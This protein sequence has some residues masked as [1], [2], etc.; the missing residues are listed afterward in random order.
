VLAVAGLLHAD[1]IWRDHLEPQLRANLSSALFH[2]VRD[3]VDNVFAGGRVLLWATLGGALA[4]WQISG[5][6][7]AVMGALERIYDSPRE[8]PRLKRYTI[9]FVLSIELGVCFIAVA[10]CLLFAPF[11][12]STHSGV[13]LT[14]LGV[15]IR[16]TLATMLLLLIVGLLVRHAPACPQPLPWVSLGAGI[17]IGTWLVVS[18]AFYF[19][20]ADIASYASVFGSLAAVI[21]AFAYLYVSTTVFLFGAQLDA[22][23]RVRTTGSSAGLAPDAESCS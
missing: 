20:L 10:F 2:V 7:R 21:V 22:I 13:V 11:F 16:W 5:A 14:V 8:R 6:V 9:S 1:G 23:I 12:W 18:G 19:Y 4:L 3:S 15:L 17:V